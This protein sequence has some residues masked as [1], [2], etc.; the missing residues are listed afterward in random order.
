MPLY[1][2]LAEVLAEI[3]ETGSWQPGARF[4]SEREIEEQF[5]VSR[6]VIRPALELLIGD[7]LIVSTR[8]R[9]AT[10]APPKRE[11]LV[12]GLV[13]ALL[14]RPADLAIKILAVHRREPDR[15]VT[16]LLQLGKAPSPV[17]DVTALIDPGERSAFLLYSFSSVTRVP[18]LL[19]VAEGLKEGRSPPEPDSLDL[20]RTTISIEGTFFSRWSASQLGVSPG[21]P[22][23]TGRLVQ[24]GGVDGI[25]SHLP[26]EFARVLYRVDGAQLTIDVD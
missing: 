23:L 7:G 13:K 22:A 1:F 17:A 5:G 25:E 2:Q 19:P 15:T 20:G 8:G 4:P 24:Y 3:L 12:T 6:T 14:E 16:R 18:W 11:I 9:G 10:V 21:D 26:L